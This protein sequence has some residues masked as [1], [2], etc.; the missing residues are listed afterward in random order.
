MGIRCSSAL[1]ELFPVLSP[2]ELKLE[3]LTL[4]ELVLE[5]LLLELVPDG[6]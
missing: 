6:R 5:E 3:E 1:F 4:E 2:D